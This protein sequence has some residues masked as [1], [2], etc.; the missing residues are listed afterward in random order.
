MTKLR[1]VDTW[2]GGTNC[3]K[4][5]FVTKAEA[6]D[7]EAHDECVRWVHKNKSYSFMEA[8]TNQG[9]VIEPD[10]WY[11]GGPSLPDFD[12]IDWSTF[13]W[14][15]GPGE[16][17]NDE[18]P[19]MYWTESISEAR[20]YIPQTG[21][22]LYQAGLK[23]SFSELF[24]PSRGVFLK[25]LYDLA[26]PIDQEI[27]VSNFLVK[28]KATSAEVLA[29]LRT[30]YASTRYEGLFEAV[31]ALYHDLYRRKHNLFVQAMVNLKIDGHV[32]TKDFGTRHLVL[33]NPAVLEGPRP[34]V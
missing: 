32:V 22:T 29:V 13:K 28:E 34:V 20:G 9:L 7:P 31:N 3:R 6:S 18:G 10:L 8:T 2:N 15:R 30:E 24:A 5:V 21:G 16:D 17:L 11:H 12:K 14:D 1:I 23:P 4:T 27:F 19:G 25:K 26:P 33:W